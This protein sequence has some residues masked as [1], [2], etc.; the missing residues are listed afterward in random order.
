MKTYHL[1]GILQQDGWIEN[2]AVRVNDKG[3]IT[4]ISKVNSKNDAFKAINGYA[5]PGF[6]NAHSHAF[7]YAMA[8][9]AEKHS[10]T[11]SQDDFWGWREAMYQLALGVNPDQM[12]AIATMLYS[13]MVRHGYTN[14]AEFHYVHHDKNGQPYN[15]LAEM[16]SRLVSAAKTAGIGITLVPIFYQKGGFGQAPNDRQRRFISP[17]VDAYLKLW[18]ASKDVCKYYEHANIGV[19]IHSMRGVETEAIKAV[20]TSGPQDIPFHIHVSEQLKEIED[21]INY[22][23]KR[24]VE[25]LL[26]NMDL[27]ERFHLV[28][29]T[30]LTDKE[31][32]GIA[33]SKAHVVLCPSTEGNLGDGLFPLH[34]FQ[35]AGG[36]WSI[37]TDSHVGL[38]PLEEL[39]IL[40]YGQ[41]LITHKRKTY[42]SESINDSG[43][44]AINMATLAG[45]K[46]M[47]NFNTDFFKVGTPFNALVMD[48]SS[49]LISTTSLENLSS[50]FV[51]SSDVSNNL[52]TISHGKIPDY[53]DDTDA[54]ANIILNFKKAIKALKNR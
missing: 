38:N 7:Q 44:F 52:T 5:I 40:D 45:R 26:E 36:Q 35:E 13:E 37:G 28:H 19:G 32:V 39:R 16:G 12:E 53:L 33:N 50:T 54:R 49:P 47:N 14:V 24:P 18:E 1:K 31:T 2:A 43:L 30:H 9:L 4:E 21:S 8:G 11:G 22:L 42:A 3:I 10:H 46:A 48:A 41:R 20:A 34:Q 29:A 15:N 51:Y 27:N 25:W 6:Q 23:G 17:T